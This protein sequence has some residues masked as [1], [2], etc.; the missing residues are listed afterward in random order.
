MSVEDVAASLYAGPLGEFTAA[1]DARAKA[2]PDRAVAARIRALRKPSVA[3]SVVN[4]FA[5]ERAA[6][7]GEALRL[8]A[9][10][11]DAQA[12][13]DTATL[14][15]LGRERRALTRR[16]ASDAAA[17]ATA[18]GERVTAATV[19][20]VEQTIS[21]AFFDQDAAAA[22]A[23][24][25]LVHELVPS[26]PVDVDQVV[27]G[28]TPGAPTVAP[29]M[30]DEVKARRE[31][32]AAENAL[33]EAEK[34]RAHAVQA[35]TKTEQH[36]REASQHLATLEAR[37]GELETELNATRT[38]ADDARHAITAAEEQHAATADQVTATNAAVDDARRT[39][40][41]LGGAEAAT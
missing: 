34:D 30:A 8:A 23:S 38:R 24:G 5:R 2:E 26:T 28:G 3:A 18:R 14:T 13:L 1:R 41:G 36:R 7:L 12:G 10:L 32:R 9:E 40:E 20:A 25:R 33:R 19:E 15:Q 27:G 17:L 31:R 35:Q 16:L 21:A 22:V 6:E 11:R 39:L 4:L 29:A 37:I